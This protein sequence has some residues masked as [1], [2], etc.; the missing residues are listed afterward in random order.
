MKSLEAQVFDKK[1][2]ILETGSVSGSGKEKTYVLKQKIE[3]VGSTEVR[4]VGVGA[5]GNQDTLSLGTLN[6]KETV[7][8]KKPVEKIGFIGSIVESFKTDWVV[9]GISFVLIALAIIGYF[10]YRKNKNHSLDNFIAVLKA[11]D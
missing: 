2:N 1:Y 10:V 3:D 5:N 11:W 4:I 7:I 6:V 9:Y 8:T